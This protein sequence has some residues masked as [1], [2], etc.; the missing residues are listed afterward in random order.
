[1]SCASNSFEN[2]TIDLLHDNGRR[3]DGGGGGGGGEVDGG[4]KRKNVKE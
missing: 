3:R 1:M 4:E 2:F